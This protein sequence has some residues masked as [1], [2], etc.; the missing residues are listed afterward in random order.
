[1]N[2][3]QLHPWVLSVEVAAAATFINALAAIPLSYFLARSRFAGKWVA[4]ALVILPL[5]MPPTVVGF[6]LWY[7]IGKY[8]FLYGMAHRWRDALLDDPRGDSRQQRGEFSAAGVAHAGG[9]CR[10]AWR[11]F[12]ED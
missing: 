1:M 12:H 6:G 5:V 10:R 3:E 7:V 2:W 9:V 11:E 4:E 8:G